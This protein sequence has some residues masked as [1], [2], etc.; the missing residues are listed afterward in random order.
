[1]FLLGETGKLVIRNGKIFITTNGVECCCD[2]DVC[3]CEAIC[4]APNYRWVVQGMGCPDPAVCTTVETLTGNLTEQDPTTIPGEQP[5]TEGT[6]NRYF[7][8]TIP[9]VCRTETVFLEMVCCS[10]EGSTVPIVNLRTSG[11]LGWCFANEDCNS[12][13]WSWPN[14]GGTYTCGCGQGELQ[15]WCDGFEPPFPDCNLAKTGGPIGCG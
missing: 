11:S 1:M 8:A 6:I 7:T 10:I 13:Y 5:C 9:T 12:L 2:L 14:I 4:D 3:S 15:I